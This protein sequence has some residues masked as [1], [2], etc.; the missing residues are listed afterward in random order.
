MNYLQFQYNL[1]IHLKIDYIEEFMEIL[2]TLEFI[3]V[4]DLLSTLKI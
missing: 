3:V 2:A 4:L 1:I